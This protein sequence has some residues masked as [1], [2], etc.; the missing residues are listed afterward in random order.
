MTHIPYRGAGPALND[1]VAG[2]VP[3][4]F[5]NMP[6]A[7]PFIKDNR[8]I[9]HGGGRAAATCPSCPMCPPSRSWAWSR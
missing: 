1:T 4:I 8:L 5:D 9:G 6:S 3:L 2:Q 7:L